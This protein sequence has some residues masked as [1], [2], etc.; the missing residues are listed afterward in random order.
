MAP[1]GASALSVATS[2]E[3]RGAGATV[4]LVKSLPW[5]GQCLSYRFDVMAP[6]LESAGGSFLVGTLTMFDSTRGISV[7]LDTANPAS[8]KFTGDYCMR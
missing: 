5:D 2:A 7:A 3:N 1:G 8:V 4:L 6:T